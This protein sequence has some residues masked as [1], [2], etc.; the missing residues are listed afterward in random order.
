[1]LCTCISGYSPKC[2]NDQDII[3]IIIT[4]IYNIFNIL[5][6]NNIVELINV[7]NTLIMELS[8]SQQDPLRRSGLISKFASFNPDWNPRLGVPAR[9]SALRRALPRARSV[10]I[11]HYPP[12]CP[13]GHASEFGCSQGT[14]QPALSPQVTATTDV[15]RAH[16]AHN[17]GVHCRRVNSTLYTCSSHITKHYSSSVY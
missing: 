12:E 4:I 13:P 11:S 10:C 8:K 7:Y 6:S 2:Y 16:N 15:A 1:M 9:K 5:Y 3:I 17:F 14:P